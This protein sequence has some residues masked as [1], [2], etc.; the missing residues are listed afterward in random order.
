M[1]QVGSV[2]KGKRYERRVVQLLREFTGKNFRRTPGSGGFNKRH[3]QV[4]A[5][6]TF[7]GDVVYEDPESHKFLY[8]IDAKNRKDISLSAMLTSPLTS[9]LIKYWATCCDDAKDNNKLPMVFFK[10]NTNDDWVIVMENDPIIRDIVVRM[11]IKINDDEIPN[12]VLIS[13]KEFEKKVKSE[14]LFKSELRTET[15]GLVKT[16]VEPSRQ[17]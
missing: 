12:P 7:A 13:W 11:I 6:G 2:R 5:K 16:L 8:V 1:D 17:E 4:V 14:E 15:G 10:P 3:G 9:K